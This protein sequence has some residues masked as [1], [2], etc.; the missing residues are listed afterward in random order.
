MGQNTSD[1][2]AVL[3]L[4]RNASREQVRRAYHRLA[5]RYHPDLH[6]D[7][8]S[9]Q[10]R[11]VNEAWQTLSSPGRRVRED[12][13]SAWTR[14]PSSG[15]WAASRRRTARTAPES[16][17]W[18]FASASSSTAR[19]Y[20]QPAAR[21]YDDDGPGWRT[22]VG[23]VA[24]GLLLFLVLFSGILPAPLLGIALLVAAR[25]ISGARQSSH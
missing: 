8:P 20:R 12:T 15:H 25:S 11:R 24:V 2:Y 5:K 18:D 17:T 19:R 3:G 4:P 13:D 9:E 14:P 23:T 7:A 21:S 22:V 16:E 6:P 10:M 1:P